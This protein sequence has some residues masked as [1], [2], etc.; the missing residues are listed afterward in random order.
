MAQPTLID[1]ITERTE[2]L[3]LRHEELRREHALLS[4]Q[5]RAT[6]QERDA[7]KSRLNAARQRIDALVDKWPTASSEDPS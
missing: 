3:L 2:R 6:Q 4:E 1:Q 7:L 5:L